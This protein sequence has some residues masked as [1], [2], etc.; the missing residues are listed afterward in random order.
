M[1]VVVTCCVLQSPAARTTHSSLLY[2][3]DT[4]KD[5]PGSHGLNCRR[6]TSLFLEGVVGESA[7]PRHI[8]TA[9]LSPV[10]RH[11]IQT[12][13]GAG[14]RPGPRSTLADERMGATDGSHVCSTNTDPKPRVRRRI[15]TVSPPPSKHSMR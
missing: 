11:E 2:C 6:T 14:A 9:T 10:S 1:G 4:D 15:A 8:L 5:Q 7:G 13:L 3:K 12:R